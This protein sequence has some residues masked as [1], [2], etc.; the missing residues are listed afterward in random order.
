VV[1][2][3]LPAVAEPTGSTTSA[4]RQMS[5][6]PTVPPR[7]MIGGCDLRRLGAGAVIVT[8]CRGHRASQDPLLVLPT[9][10]STVG[11]GVLWTALSGP[12]RA[13]ILGGSAGTGS[14]S[15]G[16]AWTRAVSATTSCS[17]WWQR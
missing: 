16:W 15:A 17:C 7:G 3:T 1:T 9:M 4:D 13:M 2:Q 10:A 11:S 8:S 14:D 12:C 5:A 6:I